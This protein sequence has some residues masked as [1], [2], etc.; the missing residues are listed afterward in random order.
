VKKSEYITKLRDLEGK[1]GVET[2]ERS[3]R[4]EVKQIA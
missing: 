4:I 3:E 2:Q 1:K